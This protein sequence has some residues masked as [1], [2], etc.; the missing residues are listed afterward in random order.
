MTYESTVIVK[1]EIALGVA[2][3]VIRMSFGRRMELMQRIRELLQRKEFLE[4]SEQPGDTMDA[5][6]LDAKVNRLYL[7]WGLRAVSG[8]VVDGAA[9]TPESLVECGPE[10]LLREALAAVRSEAGL[11]GAERKN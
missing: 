2:Y 8:L 4:A 11:S 7:E 3:T 10:D 6:L 5:A 9:A 1:S